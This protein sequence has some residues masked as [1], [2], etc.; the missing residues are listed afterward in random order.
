M[1]PMLTISTEEIGSIGVRFD[2][3]D[4]SRAQYAWRIEVDDQVYADTDLRMG[5]SPTLNYADALASL[6]TFL[7]AFAESVEYTMRTGIDGDNM[8]LFP[9]GLREWAYAVG[10][11]QFAMLADDLSDNA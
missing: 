7:G 1:N 4:G 9:P 10:S 2:R 8:G 6:L 11:D 5:D 3:W